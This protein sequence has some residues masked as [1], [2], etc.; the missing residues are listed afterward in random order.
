LSLEFAKLAGIDVVLILIELAVKTSRIYEKSLD[1]HRKLN[2][3]SD[4]KR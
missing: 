4:E 2:D 3:K 1:R